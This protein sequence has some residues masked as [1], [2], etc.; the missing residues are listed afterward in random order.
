MLQC[1]Y[2]DYLKIIPDKNISS[3]NEVNENNN[4]YVCEFTNH[5]FQGDIE[6]LDIEY[7]C[8]SRDK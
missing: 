8:C 6:D 2:C 3:S 5:V 4:G 7:P 1:K